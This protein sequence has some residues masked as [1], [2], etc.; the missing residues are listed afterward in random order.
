MFP[1]LNKL[2]VNLSF[3]VQDIICLDHF[4]HNKTILH[5]KTKHH[6]NYI[7]S[8]VFKIIFCANVLQGTILENVILI[9]LYMSKLC[10]V[11]KC[12]MLNFKFHSGSS[13]NC[14]T[15]WMCLSLL[16]YFCVHY[17]CLVCYNLKVLCAGKKRYEVI[18]MTF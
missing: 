5:N 18:S 6:R 13:L 8:S 3:Q 12:K 16:F 7:C 17:S 9:N 4:L 10:L 1:V 14:F 2:V 11:D 15:I